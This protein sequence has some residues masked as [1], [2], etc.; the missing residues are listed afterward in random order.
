MKMEHSFYVD[1]QGLA[2]GLALWWT[3]EANI[4]ILRYD[5]NYIDTK[6]VLQEGEAWFGTFIYGS[7]YREERQAF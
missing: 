5:K 1:P 4:T 2:G 6:I 3:G 7:P